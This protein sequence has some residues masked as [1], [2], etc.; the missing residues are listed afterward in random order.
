[1]DDDSIAHLVY[2]AYNLTKLYMYLQGKTK[3]DSVGNVPYYLEAR[4]R[5]NCG[6]VFHVSPPWVERHVHD[7]IEAELLL[8][9]DGSLNR[10]LIFLDCNDTPWRLQWI[11][12][13]TI[14]NSYLVCLLK[15]TEPS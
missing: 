5:L 4:S 9:E 7:L 3:A 1:M 10:F 14:G 6:G 11:A 12:S 13:M 8:D 2:H 15:W